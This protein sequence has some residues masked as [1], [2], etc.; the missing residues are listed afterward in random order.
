MS[1]TKRFLSGSLAG[2]ASIVV[3][4]VNQL[5]LV[6]LYLTYWSVTDYGIWLAIQAFVSFCTVFSFGYLSYVEVEF[7]RF[8]TE[9]KTTFGATVFSAASVAFFVSVSEL[10]LVVLLVK[11]G[12]LG[13]FISEND[14][15]GEDKLARA[16]YLLMVQ[17]AGYCLFTIVPNVLQRAIIPFG[18]YPRN[19]WWYTGGMVVSTCALVVAV[20]WGADFLEAG[21]FQVLV[22]A[23]FSVFFVFST[24]N[25]FITEKIFFCRPGFLIGFKALLPSFALAA[26][27]FLILL[28]QHGIRVLLAS[29]LGMRELAS[30]SAMR[31]INNVA[32]QGVGTIVNPLSPEIIKY[33]NFGDS[34]KTRI[35]FNIIWGFVVFFLGF[36][37]VVFQVFAP[38]LF[39]FWTLGKI[40]FD[41]F[42]FAGLSISLVIY[43][44]SQPMFL[45]VKGYNKL[46]LQF[47]ATASGALFI[48]V[49]IYFFA[50]KFGLI[51]AVVGLLLAELVSLFVYV[52]GS[53]KI[54]QEKKMI[55]PAGDFY[56]AALFAAFSIFGVCVASVGFY[57]DKIAL[58]FIIFAQGVL[59]LRFIKKMSK[60]VGVEDNFLFGLFRK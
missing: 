7:L 31:T 26:K 40:Q 52:L 15:V 47:F 45:I 29:A 46:S 35:F 14:G 1:V 57:Y 42:V 17:V 23:V 28:N 55:W 11:S 9:D 16:G 8:G 3:V 43:A 25:I 44:L 56:L 18:Y 6:P 41:P 20:F 60:M 51:A 49:S 24:R 34:K 53:K 13:Y 21:I 38:K 19:A 10:L 22:Y 5:A 32:L 37:L 54:L 27:T 48:V 12:I 39:D 59:F 36:F 4:V 2:W 58:F 33:S 50:S 30:F